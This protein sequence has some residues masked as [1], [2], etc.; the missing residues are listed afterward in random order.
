MPA[1]MASDAPLQG[2][3][4]LVTRPAHQ[5]EAFCSALE[6]DGARAI[7]FPVIA[8]GPS[9]DPAAVAALAAGL[10]G[11]QL[12][13]F[14]SANAVQQGLPLL[15]PPDDW[16]AGTAIAA[17]GS[18][19]AAEL[20]A[21]GLA[22]DLVPASGHDSE[23]LLALP[24]LQEVAGWRV[25][26]V[27]GDGG[28]EHLAET[29]QARGAQVVYAEVYR[30]VLPN[31]DAAPLL[32]AWRAGGVDLVTVTSA[33]TLR[34][35]WQLLGAPGQPLLQSTPLLLASEKVRRVALELGCH[36][37]LEVAADATDAAMLAAL[38]RWRRS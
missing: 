11:F 4:V 38:R 16:P 32:R 34:N 25:L 22:V 12:A 18:R 7:R 19:T 30:R 31:L 6:R 3:R 17:V 1:R 28:R 9:P 27:R 29:L 33:Q 37:P 35:L 26:I 21:Q 24:G 20:R 23:A 15:C 13:V 2:L 8:I 10:A 5:A 36:G 14:I